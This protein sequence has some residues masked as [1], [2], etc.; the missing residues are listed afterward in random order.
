MIGDG[1]VDGEVTDLKATGSITEVGS[2]TNTITYTTGTGFKEGNY[3][4]ELNP[5]TLTIEKSSQKFIITSDSVQRKY[6]GT[7]LTAPNAKVVKPHGFEKFTVEAEVTGNI[8]NAGKTDNT[9]KSVII[10]NA[11]GLN[12]TD[13]FAESELHIGTLEVLKRQVT[14]TSDTATK[15]YDGAALNAPNVTVSGDGWAS[16]EDATY[17]FTGSQT[18][19]GSSPNTFTY[20]L[21]K[22]AAPAKRMMFQVAELLTNNQA[23]AG[24]GQGATLEDNY[25]ITVQYGTLTVTPRPVTI[26]SGKGSWPYD[27]RPHSEENV[28]VSTGDQEGFVGNDGATFSN[29]K[30]IT[31]KGTAENTFEYQLKEGTIAA[32]YDI[33][34][35]YGTLEITPADEVHI[36]I[37]GSNGTE[38]YDGTEKTVSGYTMT[39]LPAGITVELKAD[40]KAE[41]KGTNAGEYPMGLTESS[42]VVGGAEEY[43][44][45]TVTVIDGKLTINKRKVTLTSADASKEYDGKVLKAPEVTVTGDGFVNG[46]V[47]DL[48]ATGSI[49]KPGSVKNTIEYTQGANFKEDNYEITKEEGTLTVTAKKVTDNTPK[50]S[51]DSTPAVKTGDDSMIQLYGWLALFAAVAMAGCFMELRK[52]RTR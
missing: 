22:V 5:G 19:A 23:D 1:F 30:T 49:T 41:A 18:K 33:K 48:R 34:Q 8:T 37:T 15:V 31:N 28:T 47:S 21:K 9:I 44:K 3:D 38:V 4:I 25:D 52:R 11:D 43:K 42:F 32:N 46:E 36:I 35:Q 17:E 39:D 14:I 40:V 12:V 51:S 20:Q 16:G 7:S 13:C 24:D 29:F 26:T 2:T 10:R 50:D 27:G 6:D 45:V